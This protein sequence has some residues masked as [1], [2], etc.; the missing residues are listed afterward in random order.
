MRGDPLESSRWSP[1][2]FILG[3]GQVVAVAVEGH[4]WRLAR[5]EWLEQ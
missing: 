1:Q 3:P 5:W 2:E 4:G